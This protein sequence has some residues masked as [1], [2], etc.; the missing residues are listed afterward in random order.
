MS[1][2]A[3]ICIFIGYL[4]V[5]SITL[6]SKNYFHL[7]KDFNMLTLLKCYRGMVMQQQV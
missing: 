2:V 1:Q 5:F 6:Y 3:K 7:L 4:V